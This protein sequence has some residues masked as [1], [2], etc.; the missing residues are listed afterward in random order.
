MEK[1]SRYRFTNPFNENEQKKE[2]NYDLFKD[3]IYEA[4]YSIKKDIKKI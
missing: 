1:D 4:A 3:I 2:S